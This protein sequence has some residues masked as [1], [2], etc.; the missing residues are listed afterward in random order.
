MLTKD[1]IKKVEELGL[2][3]D[4]SE[5]FGL[6]LVTDSNHGLV[7]Y[8]KNNERSQFSTAFASFDNLLEP[9]Q[10]KLIELIGMYART[11]PDK[12]EKPQK[13]YLRFTALTKKGF[14]NYLN[15]NPKEETIF[16]DNRTETR[17]IKTQFTQAEIDEIKEKFKVTLWDFEQIPIDWEE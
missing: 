13:Y 3:V 2:Y 9:M 1:F 12:R 5:K 8:V 16:L 6:I 15:Y 7:A 11:L 4:K 10:R 17:I 14:C